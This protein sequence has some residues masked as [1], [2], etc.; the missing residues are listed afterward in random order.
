MKTPSYLEIKSGNDRCVVVFSSFAA[1]DYGPLT[2]SYKGHFE[3]Y[4]SSSDLIFVKDTK[5]QWYNRQ[6]PE[7][8]DNVAEIAEGLRRLTKGY[9]K[10][11]TFGSSMGGYAS[12]LYGG[13][14]GAEHIV[15]LS[16]QTLLREPFPR[17]NRK[18]HKGAYLDLSALEHPGAPKYTVIVGEEELFDIYQASEL[19]LRQGIDY[20]VAPTAA[21][22]VVKLLDERGSLDRVI[23]EICGGSTAGYT[24]NLLSQFKAKARVS[25][26][27]AD[28]EFGSTLSAAVEMYY[29][30]R[31]A[32]VP[33]LQRLLSSVPD[34]SGA[35]SKLGMCHFAAG[36]VDDALA[37][38]EAVSSRSNTIYEFYPTYATHLARFGHAERVV[39][40]AAKAVRMESLNKSIFLS[41]AEIFDG[42]NME[43]AAKDCRDRWSKIK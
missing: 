13:L 3:K 35:M 33:F 9:R 12:I 38:F 30:D 37:L 1:R 16:P 19:R 4:A 20:T 39:E 22:N 29:M 15:A 43:A 28:K 2:F 42:L 21:H 8:G 27:L 5:N 17:Y 18:I 26:I 40:L 32:A 14:L 10:I 23:E 24:E 7:L 41:V 34:W 25:E 36:N 6:L 31:V 11:S